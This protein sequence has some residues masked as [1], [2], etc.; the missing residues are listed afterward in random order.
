MQQLRAVGSLRGI[1]AVL[2]IAGLA[3]LLAMALTS[4]RDSFVHQL[5]R[6]D[7]GNL[8]AAITDLQYRIALRRTGQQAMSR[9]SRSTYTIRDAPFEAHMVRLGFATSW[10]ALA[11]GG[12]LFAC[13][14]RAGV[15][16]SSLGGGEGSP[17]QKATV[18]RRRST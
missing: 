14:R 7:A 5:V 18:H 1:G 8:D 13:V 3:G 11:L 9:V 15:A 2:A 6:L 17:G 10:T 16:P 12:V 4:G